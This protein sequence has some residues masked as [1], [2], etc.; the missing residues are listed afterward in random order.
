[1]TDRDP[2]NSRGVVAGSR[3]LFKVAALALLLA[4]GPLLAGFAYLALLRDPQLESRH[5]HAVSTMVARQQADSLS[6]LLQNLSLRLQQAGTGTPGQLR[7]TEGTDP[8]VLA[9][10]LLPWFPEFSELRLVPL[11]EMGTATLGEGQF[12]LRNHIEVD[13]VRRAAAGE[14]GRPE[15]YRVDGELLTSMASLANTSDAGDDRTVILGTL[16]EQWLVSH[17]QDGN[18]DLGEITLQQLYRNDRNDFVRVGEASPEGRPFQAVQPV[19]DTA[20]QVTFTPSSALLADF[21][22]ERLPLLLVLGLL[23]AGL[24]A[25]L[26]TVVLWLPRLVGQD[27]ARIIDGA[28]LKTSLHLD[29][30]H[31][32]PLGQ[33]L[34]RLLGGHAAAVSADSGKRP[35]SPAVLTGHH[36]TNPL[37]QNGSI[38]DP[39]QGKDEEVLELD[40]EEDSEVPDPTLL[41]P[42]YIFRAYDIRGNADSELGDTAVDL[43]G[44]AIGTLAAEKNEDTLVVGCDGRESSPR[45]KQALI[46]ALL[47]AGRQ[48]IDIGLV[49]TPLL[50]YATRKLDSRSGVMVTGSHNPAADNGLKIV[51]KNHSIAGGLVQRI[52]ESA[53][54]ANFCE[55]QGTLSH[56]DLLPAYLDEVVRDIALPVPLKLVIDAGNGATSELAPRLFTELGCEVVPL[57]CDIDG[58]FPNRSPDTSRENNLA[59]LVETVVREQADLGIAFD[60]DGDRIAVVTDSGRILRTDQLLMLYVQDVVSRNPGTD[61]VF[62]I[63]CSRNL[64]QLVVTHGGRPV[65]SKTG[66]AFMKE[67]MAETGALLG[68]E[69]SGHIFFGERWYGF[70]DGLYAAARL[71]EILSNQGKTL[72]QLMAAFPETANTPEI[73]IPVPEAAKFGLMQKFIDGASFP[74]GKVNTLD[75]LRV[76]FNDGWGLIRA[77]NTSPAL[78]AR[79]EASTPEQL[80]LIMDTFRE[81]LAA[82][83]SGLEIPD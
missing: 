66:H 49:P 34:R 73:L 43:I 11:T 32:V 16:R 53:L 19:T 76:D 38:L 27:V 36:L 8:E 63:K 29:I 45:I 55:G 6:S 46:Q 69:F 2:H 41:L 18:G 14:G 80:R 74:E 9:R 59:A 12:G 33:Y 24:C 31:L 30:P 65:L 37:F 39:E 61:V 1:M 48:V 68:G 22:V 25:G 26:L 28:G 4:L 10:A 7:L 35:E 13:L 5:I 70:D 67:K 51:L 42:P 44:R 57:F 40:L 60:G 56:T 47:G 20:W 83:D 21:T 78:T 81:Q 17:L 23:L 62:D 3:T 64:A 71:A 15:T 54:E 58:S 50:Y 75:G 82:T 79:F 77:S 52:R 72:E